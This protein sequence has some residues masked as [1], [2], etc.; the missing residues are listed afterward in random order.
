MVDVEPILLVM[1]W[2]LRTELEI[3]HARRR[4]MLRSL[5]PT[6]PIVLGLILAICMAPAMVLKCE[7]PWDEAIEAAIYVFIFSF[8]VG[9]LIQIIKRGR[10]FMDGSYLCQQCQ[11]PQRQNKTNTCRCGGQILPLEYFKWIESDN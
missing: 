7:W 9:Y 10:F 1:P 2:I 8:V 6:D 5:N 4:S 3:E 11:K